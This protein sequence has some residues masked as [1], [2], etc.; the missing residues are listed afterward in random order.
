[1]Q[2]LHHHLTVVAWRLHLRTWT[3][4]V[5]SVPLL[6][7]NIFRELNFGDSSKSRNPV[8]IIIQKTLNTFFFLRMDWGKYWF[9]SFRLTYFASS[10]IPSF[11]KF[12]W[13]AWFFTK[14]TYKKNIII[15]LNWGHKLYCIWNL[16]SLPVSV[17]VRMSYVR[18]T[19][20]FSTL[21]NMRP[22][23]H[24]VTGLPSA[25]IEGY[26]VGQIWGS[27]ICGFRSNVTTKCLNF[28]STMPYHSSCS[29]SEFEL[30]IKAM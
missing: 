22:I 2:K 6:L 20:R 11:H 15:W 27:S 1:M 17:N 29:P 24:W 4:F 8:F 28:D 14:I 5:F 25:L 3:F 16:F 23:N 13:T 7:P 10:S 30:A 9:N 26:D 19:L 21:E 18:S 12:K